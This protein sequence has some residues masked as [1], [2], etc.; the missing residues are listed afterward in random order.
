MPNADQYATTIQ[1]LLTN[2]PEPVTTENLLIDLARTYGDTGLIESDLDAL[3]SSFPGVF[4]RLT[5][6]WWLTSRGAPEPG[7]SPEDLHHRIATR[8]EQSLTPIG[9]SAIISDITSISNTTPRATIIDALNHPHF[10][11]VTRGRYRLHPS[12]RARREHLREQRRDAIEHHGRDVLALI[13]AELERQ[14]TPRSLRALAPAARGIGTPATLRNA[15]AASNDFVFDGFTQR[16]GLTEWR[17]TLHELLTPAPQDELTLVISTHAHVHARARRGV[18]L[19]TLATLLRVTPQALRHSIAAQP[20]V[21]TRATRARA[22]EPKH[23]T[24]FLT[25]EALNAPPLTRITTP[26]PS[27]T[28][29]TPQRRTALDVLALQHDNRDD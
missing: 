22:G 5:N 9:V 29:R 7:L 25:P 17:G 19:E 6:G 20:R 3:L 21:F 13:R 2:A 14:R 23:I 18:T 15:L 26:E 12:E 28:K 4:K 24:I 16:W 11:R 10:E 8:L 1:R 27:S